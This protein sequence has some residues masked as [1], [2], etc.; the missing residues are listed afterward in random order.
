MFPFRRRE[1][2][3]ARPHLASFILR[4]SGDAESGSIESKKFRV[5]ERPEA[6]S[7]SEYGDGFQE[8][9]LPGS[10]GTEDD[11]GMFAEFELLFREIPEPRYT[12]FGKPHESTQGACTKSCLKP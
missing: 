12:K 1:V 10:V 7:A 6:A 11:I 4:S 2:H 3:A 9:R 5:L 8:I